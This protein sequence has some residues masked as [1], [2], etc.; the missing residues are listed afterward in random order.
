MNDY[1]DIENIVTFLL[2]KA[3]CGSDYFWISYGKIAE[4]N[5]PKPT[6]NQSYS[7]N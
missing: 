2:E 3:D 1:A 4:K 6:K 5:F 7:K